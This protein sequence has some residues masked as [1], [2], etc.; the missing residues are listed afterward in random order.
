MKK[1]SLLMVAIAAG[2]GLGMA[3]GTPEFSANAKNVDQD[4]V[5]KKKKPHKDS[6]PQKDTI[7]WPKRDTT[8]Y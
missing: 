5:P 4:T 7:G 6:L 1:K 2:I 3:Y 8:R